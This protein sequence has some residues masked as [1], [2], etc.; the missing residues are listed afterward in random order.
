[1]NEAPSFDYLKTT[2]STILTTPPDFERYCA[3]HFGKNSG[4]SHQEAHPGDHDRKGDP[5][6]PLQRQVKQKCQT[7][8]L[9]GHE[10][11]HSGTKNPH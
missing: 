2:L 4:P 9:G 1:M 6:Q 7:A 5:Q 10:S 8:S 11:P 3:N